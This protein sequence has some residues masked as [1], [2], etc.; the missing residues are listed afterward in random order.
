MY[1]KVNAIT[2]H[3]CVILIQVARSFRQI[4]DEYPCPRLMA[5][6]W[7]QNLQQKNEFIVF[8]AY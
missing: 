4:L 1:E 3:S 6:V 5:Q 2:I 7:Y 8:I